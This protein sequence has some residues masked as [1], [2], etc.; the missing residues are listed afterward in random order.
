MEV[1]VRTAHA[2]VLPRL[3]PSDGML[4][5]AARRHWTSREGMI[6]RSDLFHSHKLQ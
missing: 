3:E 4:S 6:A 1:S 5:V 2:F